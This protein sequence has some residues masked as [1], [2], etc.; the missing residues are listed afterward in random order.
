LIVKMPV[1]LVWVEMAVWSQLE[2]LLVV[3]SQPL[4]FGAFGWYW[5]SL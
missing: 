3:V 5:S 2:L 1:P 4:V